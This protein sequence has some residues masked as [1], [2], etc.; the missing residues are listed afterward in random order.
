MSPRA[1]LSIA[2]VPAIDIRREGTPSVFPTQVGERQIAADVSA[3]SVKQSAPDLTTDRSVVKRRPTYAD[4]K[5]CYITML[6]HCQR[7]IPRMPHRYYQRLSDREKHD[8][9]WAMHYT[10]MI[11]EA[12]PLEF[13]S[14]DILIENTYDPEAEPCPP[15]EFLWTNNLLLGQNVPATSSQV[16]GC[17]CC[18]PCDP[19]SESCECI[20]R[21]KKYLMD[22]ELPGGGFLYNAD[23]TLKENDYPIFECSDAC[24]CSENCTNRAS[25]RF[26]PPDR[27]Y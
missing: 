18:G 17:D 13:A 26:Q 16:E 8:S 11:R 24:G 10:M 14:P 3:T 23:G 27:G 4:L 25:I 21:Q 12:T 7:F 6:N 19:Y 9:S 15:F 1:K 20:Q 2:R 5:E 22:V